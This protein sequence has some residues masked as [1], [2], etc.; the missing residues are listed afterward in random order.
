M[1][2]PVVMLSEAKHLGLEQD[3]ALVRRQPS[4]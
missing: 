2:T 4:R 3:K 1:L